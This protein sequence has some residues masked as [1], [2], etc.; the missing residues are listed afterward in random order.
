MKK[1]RK[2]RVN[3]LVR[4]DATNLEVRTPTGERVVVFDGLDGG[5][6]VQVPVGSTGT[7]TACHENEYTVDFPAGRVRG[8]SYQ[9]LLLKR[10]GPRKAP[11]GNSIVAIRRFVALP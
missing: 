8:P 11:A 2:L 4:L 3:D 1:I 9:F 5:P 6:I 7:V 10:R